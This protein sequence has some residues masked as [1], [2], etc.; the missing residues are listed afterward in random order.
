LDF[1][2]GRC[3][4]S[5]ASGFDLNPEALRD[6]PSFIA[7]A[8]SLATAAFAASMLSCRSVAPRALCRFPPLTVVTT[9]NDVAV[10]SLRR[11]ALILI[12][13]PSSAP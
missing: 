11:V 3:A 1:A 5:K 10:P 8:A 7:C 9:T 4:T 13:E 2:A 12:A 6:Q